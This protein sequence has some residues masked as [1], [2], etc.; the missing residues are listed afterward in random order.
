MVSKQGGLI[1][2]KAKNKNIG[3]VFNDLNCWDSQV[4]IKYLTNVVFTPVSVNEC[5]EFLDSKLFQFIQR[6]LFYGAQECHWKVHYWRA[7][8]ALNIRRVFWLPQL[9]WTRVHSCYEDAQCRWR[10]KLTLC[11][12][13]IDRKRRYLHVTVILVLGISAKNSFNF[14]L[15][16][17][18]QNQTLRS[19]VGSVLAF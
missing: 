9:F 5:R 19:L 10:Q 18:K 17:L 16:N 14:Q 4:V 11:W 12:T 3:W 2:R 6:Q 8:D 13:R 7:V 15:L 1:G